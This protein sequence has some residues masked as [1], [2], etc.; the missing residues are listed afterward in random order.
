MPLRT[1]APHFQR[2]INL[3]YDVGDA[4]YIAGYIPTPNGATALAAIVESTVPEARQRA[5]LLHAAYG[6]GKSLLALVLSALVSADS[7]AEEALDT[8]TDRV[9]RNWPDEASSFHSYRESG[10]RLLPVVLSGDEG[11]LSTALIRAL[12]EALSEHGQQGLESETPFHAALA[13]IGRWEEHY[14]ELYRALETRLASQDG[15]LRS[16][17][18]SLEDLQPN[19]LAQF[20]MI[21]PTL[22][23]GARFDRYAG[24]ALDEVF[25]STAKALHKAGYDGIFVIWDEFGRF[26]EARTGDAFGPE[27]ALL[28][29]FAEFCNR[30]GA[31]QVHL[32]LITHRLLSVYASGLPLIYQQEWARI[33]ERF[34]PHDLTSDPS[35]TY[36]LVADAISTSN[37]TLWERLLEAH[38]EKF[39]LLTA[40][41]LEL[42]LFDEVAG[43][44]SNDARLRTQIIEQA[45]PLH[46][47]TVYALPR[48]SSQVAQNERTL[49][50]FLAAQ[51]PGTLVSVM[52][53]R[54]RSNTWW[55]AKLDL[56]WDYFASAIR[57]DTTGGH[58]IWS[59][60]MHGLGKSDPND[61]LSKCIV[62]SLGIFLLIG[63]KNIQT[64]A[65]LGGA[66]PTTEVL[67][68]AVDAAEEEVVARLEQLVSRRAVKFRRADGY[69]T[70]TRGSD[71]DLDAEIQA[72]LDRRAPNRLQMRQLLERYAPLPFHLPRRYNQERS[73]TR[74]FWSLY[75]WPKELVGT[76]D[77][78]F[79]KQ[80]GQ[81]GYADGAVVYVLVSNAVEREEAIKNVQ[82]L[83]ESRWLFVIPKQPL[84]IEAPLNELFALQD[85]QSNK[86]FMEQDERLPGEIDYLIEDAQQRLH[87][88]L[89]SLLEPALEGV[90]WWWYDGT[91]WR[92]EE[93]L[94]SS[95]VSPLLSSLTERWFPNTPILNNESINKHEPSKQ[96]SRAVERVI[97]AL[98]R[99]PDERLPKHLGISGFGPDWLVLRTLLIQTGLMQPTPQ[100]MVVPVPE[101]EGELVEGEPVEGEP[102]EA[103]E[104]VE[105]LEEGNQ[106]FQIQR[107]EHDLRLAAIWDHIQAF[108]NEATQTQQPAE[109]L[110]DSLLSPPYGLRR[111]VLPLLLA[112]MMQPRLP[113]LMLR[114][115]RRVVSPLTGELFTSLVKKPAPFSFEVGRWDNRRKILWEVLESDFNDYLSEQERTQQPFDYLSIGMLRWL[116]AQPRYC[117]DTKQLSREA[118]TFRNL[119]RQAQREPAR[120]L[121]Y[122]LLEL[123][124]KSGQVDQ[125]VAALSEEASRQAFANRLSE[126]KDEIATAYQGLLYSLD[127][128][129][130]KTFAAQATR[131]VSDGL[132]AFQFWLTQL[133]QR[134]EE[135][136]ETFRFNDT[137]VQRLIEVNSRSQERENHGIPFWNQLSKAV[138]GISLHDWNDQSI[139]SFQSKL[140]EAKERA[141]RE[142]VELSEDQEVVELQI[143]L[144]NKEGRTAVVRN[145]RFR[146]SGLSA[147]GQRILQNFKSTLKIAGRPLSPDERRQVVMALLYHV[148]EGSQED[149]NA[150]TKRHRRR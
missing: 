118:R 15:S 42:G 40:R 14:P 43:T 149:E 71:V 124:E 125:E 33:A 150:K 133:Q 111:G 38:H 121:L 17:R 31:A 16:L 128:F 129:A 147:H 73:M 93:T 21:Y 127:R 5:H 19:A 70:F 145:Y 117:R 34:R 24:P 108:L 144:P 58:A 78:N 104:I 76:A 62:K 53:T 65:R 22:T 36:R 27:A 46:P 75:R 119:I 74:F 87:R 68:W 138:L 130:V 13:T 29:D 140:L 116:Q 52:G 79:L 101:I 141:E 2:S 44:L 98:L 103:A 45:W 91:Q 48:I 1:I 8:V 136:L 66:I 80:L 55:L 82:T 51:E 35:V 134:I 126:L 4:D 115:N 63:D 18:E 83:P 89:R 47:L 99:Q 32:V 3:I 67:A 122:D 6:S 100:P 88:A 81:A 114:Q 28:Q 142:M 77:E 112:V 7:N 139:K 23:G 97:D 94:S 84:L 60:V 9:A 106:H 49:F 54:H 107:P 143:N 131:A 26:L 85:L 59:G 86:R 148:L 39:S 102:V 95:G 92:A 132:S 37:P 25:H 41:T 69:W 110:I 135:P 10:R 64:D 11:H 20:E 123:L 109:D 12:K 57:S 120:V 146:P 50:T 56:L 113:V 137:L 61:Q 96:Q 30:S 105:P 72:A 90:T